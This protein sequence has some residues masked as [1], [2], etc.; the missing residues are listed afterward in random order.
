MGLFSSLFSQKGS[1]KPEDYERIFVKWDRDG[2]EYGPMQ[3]DDLLLRDWSGPPKWGRFE[4]ESRWRGYGHFLKILNRLDAAQEQVVFL[5]AQGIEIDAGLSFKE[6]L[7]LVELRQGELKEIR[8]AEKLEKEKLPATTHIR[9]KMAGCGIDYP[10]N[11]TRAQAK[12]LLARYEDEQELLGLTKKLAKKGISIQNLVI[13]A[14]AKESNKDNMSIVDHLGSLI[15]LLDQ[16]DKLDVEYTTPSEINLTT[17]PAFNERV[18]AA[19]FEAE[20]AEEEIKERELLVDCDT[21]R[22]VGKLP[23]QQMNCLQ[24]EIIEK[25]LSNK[26]EFDRDIIGCI[27]AHLAN[28]KLKPL[29]D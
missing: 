29:D 25:V 18:E 2:K 8:A 27:E 10:D 15:D 21:F 19:I 23:R 9:K 11:V 28:V 12:E 14:E 20:N 3:F 1:T 5:E 17:V 16:L 24:K 7:N 6:A 4:G 22:V 13:N 26:W